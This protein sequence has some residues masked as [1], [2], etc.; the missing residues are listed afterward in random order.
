MAVGRDTIAAAYAACA[1][2]IHVAGR[3][4][5][6]GIAHMGCDAQASVSADTDSGTARPAFAQAECEGLAS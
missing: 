4:A 5:D 1:G 6:N 2:D 3:T